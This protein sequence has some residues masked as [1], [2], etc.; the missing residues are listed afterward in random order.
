MNETASLR[1]APLFR[2]GPALAQADT[3]PSS[4]PA[5]ST[6]IHPILHKRSLTTT[7]PSILSIL[8]P[9]A[10]LRPLAFRTFTKKHDL[11]LT[12]S[13]LQIL[14]AFIGKHCG[15][16]WREEGLAEGVLEEIAKSWKKAG[17]G[18]IVDGHGDEWRNILRNVEGLMS[19]GRLVQPQGLIRQGSF[20][21]DSIE[22]DR[23]SA[24]GGK[25]PLD[26][27][28]QDS[29]SSLGMSALDVEGDDVEDQ[30]TDPR[31]WLKI[32]NAYEQPRL[33]YNAT[34]KHFEIIKMKPSLLP[35]PIHKINLF[36]NRYNLVYQR[37]LRNESFQTS[38][39]VSSNRKISLQRSSST[40]TSAQ[41]AYKLTPIANL[42]G[43]SGSGHLILGLLSISPVGF[44][45]INDLTGSIE[46]DI[47]HARPVPE[48]GAWFTPGMIV[49]VDGVYEEDGSA[50]GPGLGGSEGV[51]GFVGGRFVAF[52]VGG[53]PCERREVTL[54][55]GGDSSSSAGGGFG[56]VD[57]LGVGSE[58][59]SGLRMK[60]LEQRL[61]GQTSKQASAESKGKVVILGDVQL[62]SAKTLQALRKVLGIYATEPEGETPMTFVLMGNF[63]KYAVMAKGG[64]GGSMD[65]K[66]YFDT[67]ASTLSEHPTILQ[68]ATFIFVP[69]DNDPWASA[70]SAGGATLLPK[71]A[72][73]ELLTSRIKKAFANA[74]AEADKSTGEKTE[75]NVIWA[76]NPSRLSIFGTVQEI[77]LFR[78]DM[79][80]RLRRN[81]IHFRP[82]EADIASDTELQ[83]R[84]IGDVQ[85]L[86]LDNNQNVEASIDLDRE[87]EQAESHIPVAKDLTMKQAA[88]PENATAR[89][90]VK[91]I[92]DQGYLS[93]FPLHIR[94]VL[95][96]YAGALQLYPLPTAL[97]L[98]DPEAPPFTI[99]YE[100]CHVMNPGPLVPHG[101]SGIVKWIEF[102]SKIK[103]GKVRE[104]RF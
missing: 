74:N 43:R 90:L 47:Q 81:A 101:R 1:T 79:S 34:Q 98:M 103:R 28:R 83:R 9:P 26:L 15:S 39:V 52:S 96:D 27:R 44:L 85:A 54:G 87:V 68:S 36:R 94:P 14:A 61:L 92:L 67:L 35:D 97:V 31:R 21:F 41:N 75:G 65:Y 78:D 40:I 100:G 11:T 84:Q 13:A 49:L 20:A 38:T 24:L 23:L 45:T 70:F 88:S 82:L 63:V 53:P 17:G 93:P 56:W 42:L 4:S 57:F 58:R 18:L 3:V 7:K 95:W 33:L 77:V 73:P 6:P 5:F 66:E 69:G 91:T 60:K 8:L 72:L 76:T 50:I 30:S 55:T 102:D 16:G 86:T 37:L 2:S 80:A 59:A 48:E 46:L 64:S 25:G 104:A 89:K 29:Q 51:G 71:K 22:D 99:T 19:G 32:V 62:D 10:T 12:S